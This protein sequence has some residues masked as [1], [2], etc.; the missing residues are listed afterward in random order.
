MLNPS[1]SILC[2]FGG[3]TTGSQIRCEFSLRR[4][5]CTLDF[6]DATYDIHDVTQTGEPLHKISSNGEWTI[7]N[8]S[9]NYTLVEQ[10]N[11]EEHQFP[12][13]G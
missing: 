3:R 2:H 1:T 5:K 7:Q 9:I 11:P 6:F 13:V 12:V 10:A 4:S 8:V